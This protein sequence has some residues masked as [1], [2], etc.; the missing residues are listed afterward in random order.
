MQKRQPI[1]T[2]ENSRRNALR[3]LFALGCGLFLPTL[4][5]CNARQES[6]QENLGASGMSATLAPSAPPPP[7]LAPATPSAEAQQQPSN[8]PTFKKITQD[9]AQ[10]QDKPKGDHMCAKC[11]H[12]IAES[13]TCELVEGTVSPLGWC[14]L[15][16]P[17]V[18]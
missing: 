7:A 13:N 6:R 8:K 17:K 18:G 15:W 1:P 12:F 10:Y 14:K 11:T 3:G 5:G 9:Q 2:P 4:S 16:T